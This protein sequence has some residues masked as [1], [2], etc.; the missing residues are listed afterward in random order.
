MMY[1]AGAW[2]GGA[3]QEDVCNPFDGE[4]VGTV[5]VAGRDD[6]EKAITAAVDGARVMRGLAAFER[7]D[8]LRRA[9]ELLDGRLDELARTIASEVGKPL[10]EARG[11][12][13]RIPPLLRTSAAEGARLH[14]ETVPVDAAANG[15]GKLAFTLRQP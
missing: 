12:A 13:A 2:R 5:A 6:A 4:V 7:A 10:V 14:G 8:I 15:A 1:V 11:E 9:A 3:R